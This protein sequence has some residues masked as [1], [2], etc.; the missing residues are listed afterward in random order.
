WVLLPFDPET[1]TIAPAG[2]GTPPSGVRG[3]TSSSRRERAVD[4]VLVEPVSTHPGPPTPHRQ[5]GQESGCRFARCGYRRSTDPGAPTPPNPGPS[6]AIPATGPSD[7]AWRVTGGRRGRR[8]QRL[9]AGAA[10]AVPPG[11]CPRGPRSTIAATHRWR[12]GAGSGP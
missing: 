11:T 10:G 5:C 12:T 9:H 3:R 2:G 6:G 4:G 7:P 1:N 8:T